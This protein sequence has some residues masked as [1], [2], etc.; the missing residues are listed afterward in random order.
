MYKQAY[1]KV[2]EDPRTFSDS[3]VSSQRLIP[4]SYA[5]MRQPRH[6][7]LLSH[8]PTGRQRCAYHGF[9]LYYALSSLLTQVWSS[10]LAGFQ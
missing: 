5:D 1:S 3:T 8:I 7:N 6:S 10:Q 4:M 2:L 9:F